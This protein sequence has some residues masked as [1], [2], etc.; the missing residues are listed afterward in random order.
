MT[1]IFE[2]FVRVRANEQPDNSG[3]GLGLPISQTFARG[4]G[5]ALTVASTVGVGSAFTLTLPA[6]PEE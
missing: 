2:P 6:P 4:M 1:R 3:A 5:G